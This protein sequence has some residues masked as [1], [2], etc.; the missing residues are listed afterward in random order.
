MR[1]PGPCEKSKI[2]RATLDIS[3]SFPIFGLQ[4]ARARLSVFL[5]VV[6]AVV[7]IHRVNL[8]IAR[9]DRSNT[10]HKLLFHSHALSF[11]VLVH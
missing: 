2:M 8:N 7:V 5:S 9:L 4:F 6:L 1:K 10:R 3:V 11:C